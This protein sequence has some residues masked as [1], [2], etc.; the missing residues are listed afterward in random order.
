MKFQC[1]N[2][3]EILIVN[4]VFYHEGEQVGCN[5]NVNLVWTLTCLNRDRSKY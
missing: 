4:S 2:V 1:L 3:N 5:C